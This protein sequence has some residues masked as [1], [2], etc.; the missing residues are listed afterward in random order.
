V[1]TGLPSSPLWQY[2]QRT[3]SALVRPNIT[4]RGLRARVNWSP[5][6][7]REIARELRFE[8]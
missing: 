6:T 7:P 8:I 2:E 4:G 5:P 1:L 3:P